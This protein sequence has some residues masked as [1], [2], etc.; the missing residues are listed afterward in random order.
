MASHDAPQPRYARRE[1]GFR[2]SPVR[3]VFELALQPQFVALTGGNP[4]TSMLP[5]EHLA[6]IAARLL[7]DRGTE[8]LQYGSG[9]GIAA[10]TETIADLMA[11]QGAAVTHENLLVTTGSQLGIDLAIKLLCDPHD[12]LLAEGPTYVGA[13]GVFGAYEADL[14]QVLL[15][16]DG[17]VPGAVA[18]AIDTIRA[19]GRRIS[20]L[21]CIPNHQNP[22]GVTLSLPRRHELAQVCASR[23]VL[24][25]E[26]DP[27][28]LMHFPGVTPLPSLYS[29]NP[30]GVIHLGSF[31]K[32]F[33]P[34][35]RVGWM[36]AP[37]QTR[38]RLQIAGESVDIHPTVLAQ[39]IVHAY[40]GTPLW[41]Q[42]LAGLRERYAERCGWT[43][44][45]LE[46]TMPAGVRWT[47]PTGGFFTWLTIDGVDPAIDLLQLAIDH[48]LIIV[49]GN[50]CF[51]RLPDHT[52]ARIAYSNSSRAELDEGA[53][54]LATVIEVARQHS[55]GS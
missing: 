8:I 7:R 4:D 5:H 21:Y 25:V 53:R 11:R 40:V 52:H 17:L 39:E 2:P 15:D 41:E 37:K 16:D 19:E 28:A 24:I 18:D 22:S 54:R 12:V 55:I 13:I 42:T 46:Q 35:L 34:G 9:A 6:E 33:S 48:D 49:P 32:L 30:D 3:A 47:Q 31:S 1:Q 44:A 43:M 38:D 20:L 36:A 29:I 10:L 26:D 45:A 27:Y 23:G 14:R 51:A 50:A